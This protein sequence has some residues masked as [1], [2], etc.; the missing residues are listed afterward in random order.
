M[1]VLLHKGG[2]VCSSFSNSPSLRK[3]AQIGGTNTANRAATTWGSKGRREDIKVHVWCSVNLPFCALKNPKVGGRFYVISG[4]KRMGLPPGPRFSVAPRV[5]S[6]RFDG[7]HF[8]L[9]P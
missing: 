6:N 5:G 2:R 4:R 7:L 8:V 3:V 9:G 1:L